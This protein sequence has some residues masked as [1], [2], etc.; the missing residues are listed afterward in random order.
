MSNN[1][2]SV[3]ETAQLERERERERESLHRPQIL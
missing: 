2:R 1:S 3:I